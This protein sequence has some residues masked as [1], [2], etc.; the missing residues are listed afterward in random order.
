MVKYILYHKSFIL[1]DISLNFRRELLPL[2]D[3][4]IRMVIIIEITE[5]YN[6][7]DAV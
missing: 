5:G 7:R 1:K 4:Y 3:Y 6:N 2:I